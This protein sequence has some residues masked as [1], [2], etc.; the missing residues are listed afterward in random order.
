MMNRNVFGSKR[1]WPNLKVLYR[2]STAGTE[3]NKEIPH[4]G[5]QVSGPRLKPKTSRTRSRS[6]NYSTMAFGF[7][8][9]VSYN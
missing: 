4:S 7:P 6:V 2:H 1:L 3:E 8:E 5:L 9:A